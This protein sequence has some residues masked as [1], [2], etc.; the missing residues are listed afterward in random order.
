MKFYFSD[1]LKQIDRDETIKRVLKMGSIIREEVTNDLWCLVTSDP[2]KNSKEFEK[3]RRLG[4]TF[5]EELD[6]VKMIE[7]EIP[8][9]W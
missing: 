1:D 3:A 9:P 5:I 7:N 4:V 6:F 2:N 8:F